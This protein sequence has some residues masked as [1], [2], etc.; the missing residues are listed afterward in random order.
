MLPFE[1]EYFSR[2]RSEGFSFYI[3]GSGG[4]PVFAWPCS[5]RPQPLATVW[6]R[7]QPF[8]TVR[9]RSQPSVCGRRGCKV[10]VPM[11]KVAK[12]WLFWRVW[13]CGHVVL[14]GRRGTLWHSNMLHDASKIVLCG[15]GNTFATFSE[16]VL[17]F[18]WQAQHFG[19]LRWHFASQ[20]QHFGRVVLRVFCKLHCQRCA[21]WWQGADSM[22]GVAFCD[23][24]WKSTEASHEPLILTWQ[25]LRFMRKLAGKRRFLKLQ[26]VKSGG[27]LV[28]HARFELSTCLGLMLWLCGGVPLPIGKAAKLV[29]FVRF[30][31]CGKRV[32]RGRQGTSWHCFDVSEDVLMSFCVAGVALCDIPRVWG[33]RLS[34][35]CSCRAYGK[36]S[37]NVSFA[38]QA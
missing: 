31:G 22:A 26:S 15:R 1:K 18:S 19:H 24:S 32:L 5:W 35:G 34:W 20:A 38:W 3:W 8:A 2:M 25:I 4:W 17:H 11:G 30:K 21:K 9:N 13:S 28:Q 29:F 16:D 37:K 23:M 6:N 36:S 27:S 12:T 33:A 10:A 7:L 14:R